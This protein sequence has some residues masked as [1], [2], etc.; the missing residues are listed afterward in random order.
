[1]II[2]SLLWL[3]HINMFDGFDF[4]RDF[5]GYRDLLTKSIFN[6]RSGSDI[7]TKYLLINTSNNNQLLA[8]D[9][10][11]QI[12]TVITDRKEL[13]KVLNI[14]NDNSQKIKYIICDIFFGESDT[15]NDNALENVITLLDQKKK[16][17]IPYYIEEDENYIHYPIFDANHGLSQYKFSFLNT[18]YLKYSFISYDTIKHLPLIVYEDITG[19]EMNKRKLIG[20]RYYTMDNKWC[21]NTIIPEFR[22][23]SFNV[24]PDSTVIDLGFFSADMLGRNQIIFIGDFEG[25][26]DRHHS[27]VTQVAGPLIVINAFESLVHGDNL[28]KMPYFLF[29]FF[30]FIVIS[31]HTFYRTWLKPYLSKK[32]KPHIIID[33]LRSKLNYLLI[34]LLTLLSMLFFHH[35]IHLLILLSYFAFIEII[36]AFVKKL[37]K[38]KKYSMAKK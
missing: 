3:G 6:I 24:I 17:I 4:M 15:I 9:N 19:K 37:E 34:L 1:M 8:L 35:Y 16:L 33:F 36:I 18:Q 5:M 28:I 31:Y 13:V 23:T 22:Y 25:V 7:K 30:F 21:L 26:R 14:L 10:D 2:F 11:N 38:D 12:N 20:I 27:I 29:L 32:A